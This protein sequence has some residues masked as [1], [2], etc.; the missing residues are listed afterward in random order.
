MA[1]K[2][3]SSVSQEEKIWGALSYLWILSI[4]ALAARKNNAYIRFHA[5][6]GFF[7]FILSLFW[8]FPFFGW[9]LGFIV[10]VTAI[11]GMAKSMKGEKWA[12]PVLADTAEKSGEWLIKTIKL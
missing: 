10:I 12:L 3:T 2:K 9:I 7:L 8:W 11:V 1:V 4:V 6:Q 5:N